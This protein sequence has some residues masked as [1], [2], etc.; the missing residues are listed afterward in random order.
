[1][2][3][4]VKINTPLLSRLTHLEQISDIE[5]ISQR[6]GARGHQENFTVLGIFPQ[7]SPLRRLKL[8]C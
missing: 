5:S 2:Q 4:S 3:S 1:M 6:S 8:H 7:Q